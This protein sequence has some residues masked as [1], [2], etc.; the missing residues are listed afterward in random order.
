MAN[1]V[2]CGLFSSQPADHALTQTRLTSFRLKVGDA[3]HDNMMQEQRLIVDLN[4]AREQSTE[5]LH[6]SE[7]HTGTRTTQVLNSW[8]KV[9]NSR[10]HGSLKAVEQEQ[11]DYNSCVFT[12]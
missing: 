12:Y 10:D 7:K 2:L 11:P 8:N 6:I 9:V 4:V 5:I 1:Y 3:M